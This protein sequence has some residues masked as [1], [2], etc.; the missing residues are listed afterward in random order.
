MSLYEGSPNILQDEEK[1][2]NDHTKLVT[3]R[4]LP[5]CLFGLHR[6]WSKLVPSIS[7]K[8]MTSAEA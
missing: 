1:R 7:Y 4:E 3:Y 5:L 8:A 6:N 2:F